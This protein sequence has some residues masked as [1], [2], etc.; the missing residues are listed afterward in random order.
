MGC[1]SLVIT[2]LYPICDCDSGK[3][4][5][6]SYARVTLTLWT[7][8]TEWPEMKVNFNRKNILPD[9]G[10]INLKTKE[11]L[12][13]PLSFSSFVSP[14]VSFSAFSFCSPFAYLLYSLFPLSSFVLSVLLPHSH[15]LQHISSRGLAE[16][17]NNMSVVTDK[18]NLSKWANGTS[19]NTA[20]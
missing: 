12:W 4:Q 1:H 14:F 16:E 3:E 5:L 8:Y 9:N 6:V 7:W 20:T 17:E 10:K 13:S 2:L 19:V 11:N 15:S 18:S